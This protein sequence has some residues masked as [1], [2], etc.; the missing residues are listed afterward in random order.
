MYGSSSRAISSSLELE[1][2][3]GES[4]VEM[5]VLR[6]SDDRRGHSRPV[7]EPRER[8]LRRRNATR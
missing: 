3:G 7:Q 5:L 1:L 8:D 6:R 2:L 4:V